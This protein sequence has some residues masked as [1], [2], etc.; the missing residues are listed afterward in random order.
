MKCFINNRH[1]TIE[2]YL[3]NNLSQT[4]QNTFEEHI[5]NCDE[6]FKELRIQENIRDLVKYEGNVLFAEFLEKK[7]K[8]RQDEQDLQDFLF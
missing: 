7:R 2:N 4:E 1:K 6:C 8:T 5:F 3:E